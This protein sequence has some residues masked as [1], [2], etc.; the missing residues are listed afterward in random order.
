MRPLCQGGSHIQFR[1]ER[2]ITRAGNVIA[3]EQAMF[4]PANTFNCM[5]AGFGEEKGGGRGE[6]KEKR[7]V[8][9]TPP[10]RLGATSPFRAGGEKAGG[11][12]VG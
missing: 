3:I 12:G 7:G 2:E 4:V 6:R 8:G 9:G 10:C 5:E 1:N 11:G